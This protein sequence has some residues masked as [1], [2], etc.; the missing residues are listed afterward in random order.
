[1]KIQFKLRVKS[2][3]IY[4]NNISGYTMKGIIVVIPVYNRQEFIGEAIESVLSQDFTYPLEVIV[5][6]DCSTDRSLKI[7][8]DF[9]Q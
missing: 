5:S 6:D 9:W 1:M 3:S 8:S 4:I 2:Y 7:A